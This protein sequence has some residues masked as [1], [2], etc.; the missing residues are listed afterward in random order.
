MVTYKA[1]FTLK[2]FT[3][4]KH[5]NY[6][7]NHLKNIDR[8]TESDLTTYTERL[9]EG[10]SNINQAFKTITPCYADRPLLFC[11]CSSVCSVL[12]SV[13]F[14]PLLS[15]F[16]RPLKPRYFFLLF[17][18]FL[19]IPPGP[20]LLA[21]VIFLFVSQIFLFISYLVNQFSLLTQKTN[22]SPLSSIAPLSLFA[23]SLFSLCV[24]ALNSQ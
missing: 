9:G 14:A 19:F 17:I 6:S 24:F 18:S 3:D 12:P 4:F 16:S 5:L 15:Q 23:F 7:N 11:S 21:S 10:K 8:N 2:M 13:S 1:V 20:A 22:S